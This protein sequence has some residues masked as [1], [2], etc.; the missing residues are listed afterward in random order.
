[1]N[2]PTTQVVDLSVD[3][4][5]P[6]A[7]N[8]RTH[9]RKQI[10]QIAASIE[11]FGFTNPVLV[12]DSGEIIAGHGRVAAAKL[13]G[14]KTVPTLTLSH[15][16]ETERRAYVIADNKLAMNAGWDKEILAIELQA[17]VDLEFDVEL[18]GF[19]LAEVDFA[20]D[21]AGEADPE[22][23]DA[24]E[25]AV[26]FA[27]G[28]PVSRYGDLW[29]LGR[30]RLLCGD[31]RS[32]VDIEAVMAGEKADL[33]F[34]DPPYNVKIDGNVCG[35][36]TVKHREF[37]FASGEMNRCVS[38]F[39]V[40]DMTGNVDEWVNNELGTLDEKP[41]RS[42]LKGGYWGPI[43][44]RC[45]PVTSTHNRWFR[46]YQVGFRCCSDAL[47]GGKAVAPAAKTARI[48]HR[49]PMVDPGGRQG[50]HRHTFIE[51]R[52]HL[53][54]RGLAV[55]GAGI[56]LAIVNLSRLFGKG[57]ADMLGVGQHLA[58]QSLQR[59]AGS[60]LLARLAGDR[61]RHHGFLDLA[62]I[63]TRAGQLAV[64]RL[65][66]ESGAVREPALEGMAV[67]AS[68]LVSDHDIKVTP[69]FDLFKALRS[70]A[71]G[72]DWAASPAPPPRRRGRCRHKSRPAA[73]PLPPALRPRAPRSGCDH[74][75]GGRWRGCRPGRGR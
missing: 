44:S 41:F 8:A 28:I 34:T 71:R 57:A 29:H 54:A 59:R 7:R 63:A 23:T 36:G 67:P 21:E 69:A 42:T 75:C 62:G 10:K 72:A 27:S 30:H 16:S 15:L 49:S 51:Q 56:G 24:P 65:R 45:R 47:D 22:G 68:Q 33:V 35:L 52:F 40:R 50:R 32:T 6:Y 18:T 43:R 2:Y 9:S 46:F 5:K 37:A 20:I 13:L 61:G 73:S 31:A 38:P 17:L 70:H 14:R 3:I 19:S 55:D 39:G 74:M 1:M 53:I 48:P 25:D 58:A 66:V 4:L 64:R 12:S 60:R 26:E 11:R